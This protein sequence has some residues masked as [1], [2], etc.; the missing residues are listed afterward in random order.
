MTAVAAW[1]DALARVDRE[2]DGRRDLEVVV[3]P[4][5]PLQVLEPAAQPATAAT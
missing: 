4:C 5:A 2:Q 3:Y 1:P